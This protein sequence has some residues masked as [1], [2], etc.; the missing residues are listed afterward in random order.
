M[1]KIREIILGHIPS[2]VTINDS[3]ATTAVISTEIEFHPIDLRL[4]M[5]YILHLFIYDV[6]DQH[7]IP[8]LSTNWDELNVSKFSK[9]DF[10]DDFITKRSVHI[11]EDQLNDLV[12][13]LETPIQIIPGKMQKNTS[14]YA[15]Q[16]QVFGTL[17]P[18]IHQASAWSN[19]IESQLFMTSNSITKQESLK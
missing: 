8:L 5:E 15:R 9:G 1:A 3:A 18:A 12:L 4:K 10:K 2:G 11:K 6:N 14:L 7:D 13:H 16:F 19:P 17:V